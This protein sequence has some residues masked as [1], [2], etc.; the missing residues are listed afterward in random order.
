MFY[1]EKKIIHTFRLNKFLKKRHLIICHNEKNQCIKKIE[2]MVLKKTD[3]L[4]RILLNQLCGLNAWR[5]LFYMSQ[6]ENT[7]HCL[8]NKVSEIKQLFGR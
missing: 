8:N 3:T 2:L 1:N 7:Y 4:D 6:Y 5:Y